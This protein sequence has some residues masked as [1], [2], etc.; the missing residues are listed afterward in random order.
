MDESSF[1][2]YKGVNFTSQQF[3]LEN[4]FSPINDS[5]WEEERQLKWI[6]IDKVISKHI[7]ED[8]KYFHLFLLENTVNLFINWKSKYPK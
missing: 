6:M 8:I 2:F 3:T 7:R 1:F 4:V 5:I